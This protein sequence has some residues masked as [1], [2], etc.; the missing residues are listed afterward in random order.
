MTYHTAGYLRSEALVKE[1]EP[2]LEPPVFGLPE[3]AP[4]KSRV[5]SCRTRLPPGRRARAGM[6]DV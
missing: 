3:A 1:E 4:W 2:G 6:Q 5:C